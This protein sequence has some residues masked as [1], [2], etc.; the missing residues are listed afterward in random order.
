MSEAVVIG[1]P[2]ELKKTAIVT[3]VIFR[4]GQSG[5][6]EELI[7]QVARQ[8]AKPLAP[9]EV[10]TLTAILKTRSGKIVRGA[11]TRIHLGQDSGDL[12]SIDHLH[13]FGAI[14]ALARSAWGPA[15]WRNRFRTKYTRMG[16]PLNFVRRSPMPGECVQRGH[17]G[18]VSLRPLAA[19]RR[20]PV[21]IITRDRIFIASVDLSLHAAHG[22]SHLRRYPIIQPHGRRDRDSR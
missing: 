11:I 21:I 12:P 2:D 6:N 4:S 20:S 14:A 8:I 1:V 13:I 15:L 16:H 19:C 17:K 9:K 5:P 3:Y 22:I 7:D 10:Y 18:D